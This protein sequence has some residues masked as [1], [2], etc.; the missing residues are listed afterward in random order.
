MIHILRGTKDAVKSA[1]IE[2]QN[3]PGIWMYAPTEFPIGWFGIRL[4][5]DQIDKE[6]C[7]NVIA[8]N[9][10]VCSFVIP[11]LIHELSEKERETRYILKAQV[12]SHMNRPYEIFEAMAGVLKELLH[13][14]ER[15][16]LIPD[17][18]PL[19]FESIQTIVNYVRLYCSEAP[20]L[21][22]GFPTNL[23]ASLQD[24]HGI[25]WERT[26]LVVQNMISSFEVNGE[27]IDVVE[28][29]TNAMREELLTYPHLDFPLHAHEEQKAFDLLRSNTVLSA[30]QMDT[31]IDTIE[32]SFEN[33][34]FRAAIKLGTLLS[35][36]DQKHITEK[37]SRLGRGVRGRCRAGRAF[38][39][40]GRRVR[41]IIRAWCRRAL[42]LRCDGDGWAWVRR[43]TW[44]SPAFGV[45]GFVIR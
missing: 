11:S 27:M 40:A 8:N 26:P 13:G 12:Y 22:V 35:E 29:D 31:I 34:S 44:Y 6:K 23:K 37:T 33:Y 36:S 7:K 30:D 39:G 2:R 14:E 43:G 38:L 21:I 3:Q 18:V 16:L 17:M 28:Q 32:C 24:E 25:I 10:A 19:D 9:K 4:I 41:T 42:D 45:C 15:A 5:M 1:F 20:N